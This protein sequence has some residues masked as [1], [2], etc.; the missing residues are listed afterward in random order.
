MIDETKPSNPLQGCPGKLKY[1]RTGERVRFVRP[2]RVLAGLVPRLSGGSLRSA[3]Q[4]TCFR[5][6]GATPPDR[7][8]PAMAPRRYAQ[9]DVRPRSAMAGASLA[10]RPFE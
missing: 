2:R 6:R 9:H 7:R 10:L 1:A 4:M 5:H 3:E 8:Q